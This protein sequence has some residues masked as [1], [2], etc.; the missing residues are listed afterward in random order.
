MEMALGY[1]A[2]KAAV[3]ERWLVNQNAT[4]AMTTLTGRDVDQMQTGVDPVST[5]A[6][7]NMTLDP[8]AL[9]DL[10]VE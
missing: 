3:T 1:E 10:A 7:S 9:A 5:P 8:E 4:G 6:E 2:A